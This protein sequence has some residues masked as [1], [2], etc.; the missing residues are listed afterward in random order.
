M[1]SVENGLEVA[2][3]EHQHPGKFLF[4]PFFHTLF[5]SFTK[6]QKYENTKKTFFGFYRL[7]TA[8]PGHEEED[9]TV[10]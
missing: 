3:L 10:S 4:F 9:G 8:V 5:S 1:R 6:L 2:V 7:R